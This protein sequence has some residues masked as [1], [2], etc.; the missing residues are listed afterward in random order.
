MLTSKYAEEAEAVQVIN[1][2]PDNLIA[3]YKSF[4]L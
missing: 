1:H 2:L 3:N 4:F